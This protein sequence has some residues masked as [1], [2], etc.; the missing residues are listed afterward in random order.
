MVEIDEKH[1]TIE[2]K[3]RRGVV[4]PEEGHFG[5]EFLVQVQEE[6]EGVVIGAGGGD[7]PAGR[8]PDKGHEDP[9]DV[10]RQEGG[11][12]GVEGVEGDKV[13]PDAGE[14]H[15]CSATVLVVLNVEQ[16]L[17]QVVK[18][19]RGKLGVLG[20]G[21]PCA[22]VVEGVLE[23]ASM[24]PRRRLHGEEKRRRRGG[25]AQGVVIEA[26]S[27]EYCCLRRAELAGG[28]AEEGSLRD[29]CLLLQVVRGARFDTE[30]RLEAVV[31][32]ARVVRVRV[33]VARS[34]R[35]FGVFGTPEVMLFRCRRMAL[36][37]VPSDSGGGCREALLVSV[38]D[39]PRGMQARN[40][41][42]HSQRRES[43]CSDN[44]G[45]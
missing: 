45:T 22:K 5:T 3:P 1:A 18:G 4:S 31:R 35:V 29:V 27:R 2:R 23:G 16:G 25:V 15:H 7:E 24:V 30:A 34:E 39:A 44:P 40:L 10:W 41:N 26:R 43:P 38:G 17:P 28:G 14:I 37:A 20:V 32:R 36:K 9:G 11:Q 8:P 42:G 33:C 12:G 6:V 21:E 13:G 19:D